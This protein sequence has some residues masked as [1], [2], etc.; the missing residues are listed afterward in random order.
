[1]RYCGVIQKRAEFMIVYPGGKKGE[2]RVERKIMSDEK[3]GVGPADY[4]LHLTK[5]S[6]RGR[7]YKRFIL[8]PILIFLARKFGRKILEVGCGIGHGVLGFSPAQVFGI[9]INKKALSACRK[10]GYKVGEIAPDGSFPCKTGEFDACVLDNVL[11]HAENYLPVLAECSRVTK[12]RGGLVVVVP[13]RRGFASDP[14]HK[15]FIDEEALMNL[16]E[17]WENKVI[18]GMP[19]L[20]KWNFLSKWV[21]QYCLV[22]VFQKKVS[23]RQGGVVSG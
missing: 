1:M 13:G 23:F 19:F 2:R 3:L 12:L 6:W 21:R 18:F 14:D 22:G 10:F 9:D 11:E 5:I 4:F 17:G 8:S 15:R 20:I 7:F 16:G